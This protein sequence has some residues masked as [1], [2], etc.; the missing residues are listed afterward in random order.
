MSAR[1]ATTNAR[2]LWL[3]SFDDGV[4]DRSSIGNARVGRMVCPEG[5]TR[6]LAVASI[7]L[8]GLAMALPIGSAD[9]QFRSPGPGIDAGRDDQP[10]AIPPRIEDRGR[11]KPP[12]LRQI[13]SLLEEK[14]SWRL[15]QTNAS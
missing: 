13:E 2:V 10:Q 8:F 7:L 1:Q 3:S 12:A 6:C 4:P 5:P 11:V 9:A 15:C 14:R